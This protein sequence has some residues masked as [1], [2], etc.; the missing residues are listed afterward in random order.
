MAKIQS[1]R[2][3][4]DCLPQDSS[5]FRFVEN[6]LAHTSNTFGY[7][8]IRL[9]ILESTDLF[10]RSIGTTTDI[11]EK[12]M[13]SFEDFN[14]SSICMRP[15]GTAGCVRA[16]I[17][18]GLVGSQHRFWY[19]GPFFRHERP[20]KGRFRQFHQFGVEAF[21]MPAPEIDIELIM[22]CS[23][24]WKALQIK[25]PTLQINSLGSHV[26]RMSYRKALI[27][28]FSKYS[29][30][31]DEDCKRRIE[32]NPLRILDSKNPDLQEIILDSP[33]LIKHLEKDSLQQFDAVQRILTD[34][35]IPYEV[36][37]HLVRGLDYYNNLVFEW[38]VD[39]QRAQGSI[40][41]G[42]RYDTLIEQLGGKPSPAAG[43]AIGLERLLDVVSDKL[44]IPAQCHIYIAAVGTK[45]IFHSHNLA[46]T[47]RKEFPDLGIQLNCNGGS[48]KAQLKRADKANAE[49]SLLIGDEELDA[50]SISIKHLQNDKPQKKVLAQDL[51]KEIKSIF[52]NK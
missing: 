51:K 41:A 3:M 9:P 19:S 34:N 14:G 42:G 35:K 26:E 49:I 30:K 24:M 12:E 2:G 43:F 10:K 38:V 28:Y 20:Q 31:L 4:Q 50:N 23:N 39:K 47:L 27:D 15:E 33:K 13:Y 21:G 17:E 45:A 29:E 5:R 11:V 16:S 1:L 46:Y 22:L 40:C 36:N 44:I 25:S 37:P 18:H 7:R 52:T 8:E 48:F 32:T 6:M